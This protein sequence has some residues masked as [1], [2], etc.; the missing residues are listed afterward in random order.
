MHDEPR[1]MPPADVTIGHLLLLSADEPAFLAEAN[2]RTRSDMLW[3]GDYIRGLAHARRMR[4]EDP[5]W[6][7]LDDADYE[8]R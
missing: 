5:N 4:A 6:I 7:P 2:H 3:N 1:E 8:L